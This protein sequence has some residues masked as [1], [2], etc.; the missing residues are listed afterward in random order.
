MRSLLVSFLVVSIGIQLGCG[1][2][3]DNQKLT[4]NQSGGVIT[5]DVGIAKFATPKGWTP[6]R[7]DGNTAVI[8][9]RVNANL[10]NPDEMISIDVGAPVAADAKASAD[11]FANKFSGSVSPLP[12]AVDGAEAY[13]VSIPANYEQMLPRECIVVHHGGKLCFLI[14]GSKSQADIWPALTE[15]AKSWTWN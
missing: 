7:S 9:T 5:N 1:K 10:Q 11:G 2:P 14:G 8:L 4:V 3:K 15:I 6:N 13:R 12:F